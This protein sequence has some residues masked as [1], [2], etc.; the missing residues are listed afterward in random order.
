MEQQK[1]DL[2]AYERTFC[3]DVIR[4]IKGEDTGV[5]DK[6]VFNCPN[7]K[8]V[9]CQVLTALRAFPGMYIHT[10]HLVDCSLNDTDSLRAV[11]GALSAIQP[12]L[13]SLDLSRNEMKGKGVEVIA[14]GIALHHRLDFLNLSDNSMKARGATALANAFSGARAKTKRGIIAKHVVLSDNQMARDCVDWLW[15][16]MQNVQMNTLVL[17]RNRLS[18]AGAKM[19]CELITNNIDCVCLRNI[20]LSWNHSE[21][22]VHE[23]VSAEVRQMVAKLNAKLEER[24]EQLQAQ[25]VV[26]DSPLVTPVRMDSED[27]MSE[28]VKAW[29][30]SSD[31][32]APRSRSTTT[33]TPRVAA[34]R[35]ASLH[36]K[37]NIEVINTG[38]TEP[39]R[40]T[41]K[42]R[43]PPRIRRELSSG[44]TLF[45]TG[46]QL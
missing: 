6:L 22:R 37:D 19:L 30:T 24:W 32:P 21:D 40:S 5:V 38:T 13:K 44:A 9:V 42:K 8:K 7:N 4:K 12:Q 10:L 16:L 29:L 3:A 33:N 41:E 35:R 31:F 36:F 15:S 17:S 20:D 43:A 25:R 14:S 46:T 1:H 23:P 34:A 28:N 26:E 11:A 45:S 2:K 18:E 39:L 27:N